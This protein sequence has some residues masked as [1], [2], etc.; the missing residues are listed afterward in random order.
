M[1]MKWKFIAIGLAM[2]SLSFAQGVD[3]TCVATTTKGTNCKVV[4]KVGNLCH[5]HGGKKSTTI[6]IA[7]A[8]CSGTSKS[9]NQQCKLKTKH[10]SGRCHHHR[11]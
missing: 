2:G 6:T 11:N 3:N 10:E 1:Y 5:H 4:V 8:Q 9:T 7:S